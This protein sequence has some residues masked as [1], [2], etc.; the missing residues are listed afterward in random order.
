MT[1]TG[2]Q[3]VVKA[4]EA[5]GVEVVFGIPGLHTLPLYDA[6]YQHPH[7]RH[8]TTRHEQGAGYMAD[9]YA[10]ASGRVGVVLTTT[11]PAALNALTPLGEAYADSSPL[12]LITSGPDSSTTTDPDLGALHEMRDQFGTLKSVCGQGRRVESVEEIPQAISA[13]FNALQQQPRLR[14]HRPQPPWNRGPRQRKRT[15]KKPQP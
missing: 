8:V 12:L 14:C 11:G 13:A 10:R 3:A 15:W 5:W 9:G 4:L 2:G 6:L 1:T 7:I